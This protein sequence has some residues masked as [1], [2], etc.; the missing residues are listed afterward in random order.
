ME[1]TRTPSVRGDTEPATRAED[2]ADVDHR[3]MLRS[4]Q[5]EGDNLHPQ[6]DLG[7][8]YRHRAVD[9]AKEVS[10][11]GMMSPMPALLTR[12][13]KAPNSSTA[14]LQAASVGSDFRVDRPEGLR[15]TADCVTGRDA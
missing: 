10:S 3:G 5:V 7:L 2:R 12:L 6:E 4:L 11:I 9:S 13:S 15:T 1:L 14:L 8:V